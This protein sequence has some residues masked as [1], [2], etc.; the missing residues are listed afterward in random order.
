MNLDQLRN[1]HKFLVIKKEQLEQSLIDS[2]TDYDQL[3][4]HP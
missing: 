4:T 3:K 2:G 1:Q